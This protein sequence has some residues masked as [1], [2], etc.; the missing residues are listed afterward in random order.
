MAERLRSYRWLIYCLLTALLIS[1]P[2]WISNRHSAGEAG[3]GLPQA[4]SQ[5]PPSQLE[6]QFPE[7]EGMPETG[8]LDTSEADTVGELSPDDSPATI[9][10]GWQTPPSP[11]D[12]LGQSSTGA[13]GMSVS[14]TPPAT[15][16]DAQ[17]TLQTHMQQLTWRE[18]AMVLKTLTQFSPGEL[19]EVFQLYR[20]GSRAAYLQ[21]DALVMEKLGEHEFEKLRSLVDKYRP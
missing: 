1:A 8:P 7:H 19:L 6:P 3:A 18:K 4:V 16:A 5:E 20:Q 9:S 10:T 21:L 12:N 15:V 14:N 2:L 13:T 11:R 17:Q